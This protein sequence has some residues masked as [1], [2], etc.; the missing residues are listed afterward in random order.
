M[1]RPTG[2]QPPASSSSSSA[3]QTP[4]PPPSAASTTASMQSL[5]G[6][7]T[8]AATTPAANTAATTEAADPRPEGVGEGEGEGARQG[9]PDP[10]VWGGGAWGRLAMS[11]RA[12]FQ[13]DRFD[14]TSSNGLSQ[15]VL[16]DV[17]RMVM[18]LSA[19][20]GIDGREFDSIEL[21]KH[22]A[23]L[24]GAL[25]QCPCIIFLASQTGTPHSPP[26][27]PLAFW[28]ATGCLKAWMTVE[29]AW[30]Y[31]NAGTPA[32]GVGT[33]LFMFLVGTPAALTEQQQYLFSYA[34]SK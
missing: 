25:V 2:N 3:S 18:K 19:A 7:G 6:R 9:E 29:M 8:P 26:A 31:N 27:A 28:A 14:V 10:A 24:S 12:E 4:P 16:E 15:K 32:S 5:W 11:S 21:M 13:W 34:S 33:Q 22:R 1:G 30:R 23:A 20:K 17:K